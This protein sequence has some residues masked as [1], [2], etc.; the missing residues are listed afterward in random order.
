MIIDPK[1]KGV[2]VTGDVRF[3]LKIFLCHVLSCSFVLSVCWT[4]GNPK[5]GLTLGSSL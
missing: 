4:L 5:C 3:S 1:R 2:G